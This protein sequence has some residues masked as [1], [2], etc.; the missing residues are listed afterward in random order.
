MTIKLN[1]K[2]FVN[3]DSEQVNSLFKSGGTAVGFFQKQGGTVLLFNLQKERIG[4][5]NKHGVL[6]SSVRINGKLWHSFTTIKEVGEYPCF[7]QKCEE[8]KK[9]LDSVIWLLTKV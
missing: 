6:H 9:V 8:S 2:L 1:G 5:I 7:S 3:R 4:G